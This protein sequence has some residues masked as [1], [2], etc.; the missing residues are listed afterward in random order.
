MPAT[1]A[2]ADGGDRRRGGSPSRAA[3]ARRRRGLADLA[4]LAAQADL[5][6]HHQ[7]VGHRPAAERRGHRQ[8]HRQVGAGF[9]QPHA[10]DGRDV[11]VGPGHRHA[12]PPF[13]H[14]EQQRQAPGVDALALRRRARA[15]C[16]RVGQ[17]LHLDQERPV[18]V[19]RRHDRRAGNTAGDGR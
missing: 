9:D 10:A 15:S 5:A 17:R 7:V 14:R 16:D 3:S 1:S 4:Q 8:A 2:T 13:E 18:A 6:E 12:G 19:E 11:H